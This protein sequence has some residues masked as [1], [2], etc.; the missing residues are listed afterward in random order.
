M[1]FRN[2]NI[3]INS[4]ML[5]KYNNYTLL[6]DDLLSEDNISDFQDISPESP[7]LILHSINNEQDSSALQ[8]ED[9]TLPSSQQ[10]PAHTVQKKNTIYNNIKFWIFNKL[11]YFKSFFLFIYNNINSFIRINLFQDHS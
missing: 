5:K 9:N 4:I 11:I 3:N 10:S 6:D 1:F 8:Y 7:E 2:K